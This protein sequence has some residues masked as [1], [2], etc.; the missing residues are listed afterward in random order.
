MAQ[1]DA[2]EPVVSDEEL[3]ARNQLLLHSAPD[4]ICDCVL[5]KSARRLIVKDRREFLKIQRVAEDVPE[6]AGA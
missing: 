5:C 1:E 6:K 2:S 3:L 4:R